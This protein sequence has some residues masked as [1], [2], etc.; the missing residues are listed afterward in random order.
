MAPTLM[1][2]TGVVFVQT[3]GSQSVK[4]PKQADAA[5]TGTGTVTT[6]GKLPL[7]DES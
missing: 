6:T 5:T 3:P 1:N 4:V 7:V 2:I